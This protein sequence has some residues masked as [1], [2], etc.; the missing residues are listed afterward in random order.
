MNQKTE[1]QPLFWENSIQSVVIFELLWER[2]ASSQ[3]KYVNTSMSIKEATTK[4]TTPYRIIISS[5]L[6][7]KPQIRDDKDGKR[8]RQFAFV[9]N[10]TD[11][12][13]DS[14]QNKQKIEIWENSK[15]YRH[16]T[17][18]VFQFSLVLIIWEKKGNFHHDNLIQFEQ[19]LCSKRVNMQIVADQATW[20]LNS[21]NLT[22]IPFTFTLIGQLGFN[23]PLFSSCKI[24]NSSKTNLEKRDQAKYVKRNMVNSAAIQSL[25]HPMAYS[26]SIQSIILN[27]FTKIRASTGINCGKS[28]HFSLASIFDELSP[29]SEKGSFSFERKVNELVRMKATQRAYTLCMPPLRL[30]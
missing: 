5:I 21:S 12:R 16:A 14:A 15:V 22:K 13:F 25:N 27:L 2:R 30:L 17:E 1:G 26:F 10:F 24:L 29:F 4:P 11:S 8:G 23:Y 6:W 18:L 9:W 20:C 7:S 19:I 28:L 3:R